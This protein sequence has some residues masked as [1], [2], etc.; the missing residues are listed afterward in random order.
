M[1][2][3]HL[4]A[5]ALVLA[6]RVVAHDS[7]E[8]KIDEISFQIA[9]SGKNPEL[10]MERAY[11]HRALGHLTDA[12]ADFEAAYERDPKLGSALKELALTQLAQGEPKLALCTISRVLTTNCAADFLIARAEIL[13][14]QGNYGAALRDC[15]AAFREPTDNP[16]WYFLRAQVQRHLGLFKE[17]LRGLRD[18]FSKTGSAV[19]DEECI[20]AMIDAGEHKAALRQIEHELRDSRWRSSWLIRRARV[21]LAIGEHKAAQRD[22]RAALN[23]LNSRFVP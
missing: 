18:G 10:L 19:L 6:A 2:A 15:E 17:C 16:E 21:R 4:S 20:D 8:H 11:E 12:A 9:R 22:L 1:R 23:E 3:L 13:S 14:A 7:P 5:C